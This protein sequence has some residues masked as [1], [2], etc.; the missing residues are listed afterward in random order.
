[1]RLNELRGD[2]SKKPSQSPLDSGS[3]P[4]MGEKAQTEAKAWVRFYKNCF[5]EGSPLIFRGNRM[6]NIRK[7]GGEL[8][9]YSVVKEPGY[10]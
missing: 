5:L 4:E 8:G 6:K 7:V 1:M 2:E 9:A 10:S 3:S